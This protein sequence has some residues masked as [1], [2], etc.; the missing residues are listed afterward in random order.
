VSLSTVDLLARLQLEARRRGVELRLRVGPALR[1][2]IGF[3]GLDEPLRLE[4]VGKPESA[5]ERAGV[6]EERELG[7][8]VG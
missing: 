3:A 1:E 4:P 2:L 7:D 6:D 5:E 8:T